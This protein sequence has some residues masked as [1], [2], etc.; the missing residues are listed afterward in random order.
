MYS[1]VYS[2]FISSLPSETNTK[3]WRIDAKDLSSSAKF[4][5]EF[6]VCDGDI[7]VALIL[8]GGLM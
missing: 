1:G 3:R 5:I 7:T 6:G 2:K 8:F 4:K